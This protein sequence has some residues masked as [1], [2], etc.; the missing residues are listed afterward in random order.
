MS[1]HID[2]NL[3]FI[4]DIATENSMFNC[5]DLIGLDYLG[6]DTAFGS[7]LNNEFSSLQCSISEFGASDESGFLNMLS[8]YN[9]SMTFDGAFMSGETG[10]LFNQSAFDFNCSGNNIS[11][12]V[13][14]APAPGPVV[15]SNETVP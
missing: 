5:S 15:P 9:A 3:V 4:S 1:Y 11:Y 6:N 13:L 8:I 12:E 2:N 7:A 14:S 10:F